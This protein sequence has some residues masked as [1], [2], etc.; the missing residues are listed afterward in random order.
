M[1]PVEPAAFAA[2]LIGRLE[3]VKQE[4][5]TM[6]TL[7]E[8]LQQIKE[9]EDREECE[10]P[11]YFQTPRDSMASCDD[12]PQAILDEHLSRVLKTPGCQ[13]PQVVGRSRSPER[14]RILRPTAV[15]QSVRCSVPTKSKHVHHHYIHHHTVP[16]TMEEME[17]TCQVR[18]LYSSPADYCCYLKTRTPCLDLPLL[19]MDAMGRK[20]IPDRS[21]EGGV[22]YQMPIEESW[23]RVLESERLSK[24][25][26][27]QNTWRNAACEPTRASS[28]ERPSRHHQGSA[29]I[30]CQHPPG[31]DTTV[32]SVSTLAQL[33]E[34]CRRLAGVSRPRLRCP[35]SSHQRSRSV[36]CPVVAAQEQREP[37]SQQSAPPQPPGELTV[38]YFF[39]GEEIP[40]RRMLRAHSLTLGHFKDQLSKKGNYRYETPTVPC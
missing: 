14:S 36:P 3:K 12:D 34:A 21:G 28:A 22:V 13:S 30:R 17:A 39:C 5:E 27:A 1:T 29:P 15:V 26:S 8:R 10:T 7:E 20:V 33:E 4:Q 37:K 35:S 32:V 18:C 23:Q 6:H 24:H 16:R 2:E 11:I 25:H 40:Y 9:E 19:H 31:L 38:T